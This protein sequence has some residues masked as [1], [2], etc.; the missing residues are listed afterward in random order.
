MPKR[1]LK[2]LR[3]RA[4]AAVD[5]PC[6][7]HAKALCIKRAP[8]EADERVAAL[9]PVLKYICENDGAHSFSEVLAE[10]QFSQNVW[11]CV[12]A[13]SQS[14][15]S[16]VGDSSLTGGEREAKISASVEQFLTAVR[17]ISPEVSKR[18]E[19]LLVG[20][21]EGPTMN[22]EQALA[23]IATQKGQI[24]TLESTV[25]ANAIAIAAAEKAKTDAMADKDKADEEC[26]KAKDALAEATD[27]TVKVAG[28]EV[29]K[30]EV[31]EAN[32]TTLKAVA[33]ERDTATLEKRA[34]DE[35]GHVVG[36]PTQKALVLK[37][38]AHLPED[39]E[40][41]KALE[42]I[43]TSAEKMTAAGF[44][45]VGASGGEEPTTKAARDTFE[46]KITEIAKRDD[47]N[48]STA[49]SKARTEYPTE[50]AAAYSEQAAN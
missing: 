25:S 36:T 49:M 18:L 28:K 34:G 40:T 47:C 42:A 3:L 7:E 32:F 38:V 30:S 43:M 44:G 33:D 17:E 20:K 8:S 37:T 2:N 23:L 19:P 5:R 1:N 26:K 41:R 15:R 31:G 9:E 22:L 35:F 11:P 24:E 45:R 48:R 39:N 46:T 27:E 12:D 14:I 16:I 4:I 6:Q 21:R 13:L 10:N 50:F 29:K